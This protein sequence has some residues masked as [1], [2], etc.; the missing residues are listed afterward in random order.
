MSIFFC[1]LRSLFKAFLTGIQSQ[2]YS[3]W[4]SFFLLLNPL[5]FTIADRL[6]KSLCVPSWSHVV[7]AFSD[8]SGQPDYQ[9]SEKKSQGLEE[10]LFDGID[11]F[12][13]RIKVCFFFWCLYHVILLINEESLWEYEILTTDV[14]W[15]CFGESLFWNKSLLWFFLIIWRKPKEKSVFSE[16]NNFFIFGI[17]V[18]NSQVESLLNFN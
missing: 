1:N 14:I 10:V 16:Y 13:W 5:W 3:L 2:A 8:Q 4:I 11:F 12:L 7:W 18:R 6:L 9:K 17:K 15:I